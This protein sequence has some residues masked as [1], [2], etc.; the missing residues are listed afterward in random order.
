MVPTGH[1]NARRS[2]A[3]TAAYAPAVLSR[4]GGV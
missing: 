3:L 1:M 4:H 2:A